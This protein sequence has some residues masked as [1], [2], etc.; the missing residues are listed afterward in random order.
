MNYLF[1]ALGYV[2]IL[3]YVLSGAMEAHGKQLSAISMYVNENAI[4]LILNVLSYNLLVALWLW[5]EIGQ[6]IGLAA[7]QLNALTIFIGYGAQSLF[8]KS[9]R[10]WTARAEAKA[11]NQP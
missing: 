4:P 5:S 8:T 7:H 10:A 3:I 11:S 6:A 9:A 2:G 1:Y